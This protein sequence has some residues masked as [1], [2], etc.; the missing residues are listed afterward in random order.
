MKYIKII[1]IIVGLNVNIVRNHSLMKRG[2]IMIKIA[3]LIKISYL[4]PK[5]GKKNY[6]LKFR[7]MKG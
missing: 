6:I 1:L 7:K 2:L 5:L 4:K 3:Q